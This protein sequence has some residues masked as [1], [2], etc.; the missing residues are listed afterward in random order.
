MLLDCYNASTR[1]ARS[2]LLSSY[3]ACSKI[4]GQNHFLKCG[5][6][7]P[8]SSIRNGSLLMAK[9][10]LHVCTAVVIRSNC[11][12]PGY[13]VQN[14]FASN[15]SIGK[16]HFLAHKHSWCNLQQMNQHDISAWMV[17]RLGS[18]HGIRRH[19][20]SFGQQN[21]QCNFID[22]T[23]S[24]AMDVQRPAA[25]AP[26]A[27]PCYQS[28]TTTRTTI[29]ASTLRPPEGIGVLLIAAPPTDPTSTTLVNTFSSAAPG[30]S[31]TTPTATTTWVWSQHQQ[32]HLHQLELHRQRLHH[33][34]VHPHL[35]G[36]LLILGHPSTPS[37]ISFFKTPVQGL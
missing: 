15:G 22:Y 30:P 16:L 21:G 26:F 2:R 31:K 10:R 25:T 19:L 23:S 14:C 34:Q 4:Y 5:E 1:T 7:T 6:N 37:A 20:S 35:S 24:T 18:K 11:T 12:K 17:K 27:F 3:Y 36:S 32:Q 8:N 28:T 33:N 13:R 29:N 9:R